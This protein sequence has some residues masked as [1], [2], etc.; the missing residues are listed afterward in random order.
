MNY[1]KKYTPNVYDL[2][3]VYA[4][5]GSETVKEIID[6]LRTLVLYTGRVLKNST[7]P[8]LLL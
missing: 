7:N 8:G 2:Q 6:T 3:M 1:T 4:V 5:S